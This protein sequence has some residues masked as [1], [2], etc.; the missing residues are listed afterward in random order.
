MNF[1]DLIAKGTEYLDVYCERSYPGFL[2]E[3]WN[4]FSNA[5]FLWVGMWQIKRSQKPMPKFLGVLSILVGLGSALFHS[6]ATRWAQLADIIPIFCLIM[7]FF[8]YYQ[9][10]ILKW[11]LLQ[12]FFGSTFVVI[13]T[14][15][16]IKFLHFPEING[17][18]GYLGTLLTLGILAFWERHEVHHW[19][20]RA[21]VL[22]FFSLIARSIDHY[23]CPGF[24]TGTHFVWHILN[25]LVI[26]CGFKSLDMPRLGL[27]PQHKS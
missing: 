27:R 25:A 16:G 2:A 23:F 10:R 26:G 24:Q 22:F 18:E 13:L 20:F 8:L 19:I 1:S 3:P 4:F 17:S 12:T 15:L 9:I 5:G 6:L 7:S 11:S 14:L 21:F